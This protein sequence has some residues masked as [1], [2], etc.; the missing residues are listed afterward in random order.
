MKK[1]N[2]LLNYIY[3]QRWCNFKEDIINGNVKSVV[4]ESAPFDNDKKFFILGKAEIKNKSPKFFIM[5][6][7]KGIMANEMPLR[8]KKFKVFDALKSS[9]YWSS[10]MNAT[11]LNNSLSVSKEYNLV[12]QSWTDLDFITNHLND[13]S[14]PLNAEQ[15]NTTLIIG[16]RTLAFKQQRLIEFSNSVNP[17]V[18]MNYN[19]MKSKCSVIP[20]TYGHLF[21][22]SPKGE[23]AFVGIVQ[24]FIPNHGDLWAIL[25]KRIYE[26]LIKAIKNNKD[27]IASRDITPLKHL[28]N[29]LGVRTSE[30]LKCLSSFKGSDDLKVEAITTKYIKN[31][32]AELKN[33]AE[34]A[35][36]KIYQNIEYLPEVIRQRISPLLENWDKYIN[37]FIQENISEISKRKRKGKLMRVHGDFHLGQVILSENNELKFI[38]FSGEPNLSFAKRKE[39]HPYM[40]DIAGMYRSI[41]GYLEASVVIK[42]AIDEFGELNKDKLI[43]GYKI[44]H[45]VI[46]KLT[47]SFLK[48]QNID[49]QWL[50]LEIL[51]R[52]LYEISY[53]ISY[54]PKMLSVPVFNLLNLLNVD[55]KI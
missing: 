14:K 3:A 37:K 21:L 25:L 13:T 7:A 45:P 9:N 2:A 47:E 27:K 15:S 17:E 46:E 33:Q 31:Y 34:E 30:M 18:E 28:M 24:E 51:R 12:Y 20:K 43:L 26:I 11:C 39:K 40:Y 38:D 36:N 54:R 48:P 23:N 44:L 19:L 16:N 8:Y 5:P 6:L 53:E 10:I 29:D 41:N 52:N 49:K 32:T 22:I 55:Y 35:K 42:Y 50:N 4:L 1:T